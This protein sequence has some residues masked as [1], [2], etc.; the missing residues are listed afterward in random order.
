VY[1]LWLTTAAGKY[2]HEQD[3]TLDEL[4]QVVKDVEPYRNDW[5]ISDDRNQAVLTGAIPDGWK[6][7]IF[8]AH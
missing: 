8:S 1:R 2:H 5:V 7:S 6:T 3:G 4:I